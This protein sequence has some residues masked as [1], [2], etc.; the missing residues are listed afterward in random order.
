MSGLRYVPIDW[1]RAEEQA[2]AWEIVAQEVGGGVT[3]IPLPGVQRSVAALADLL[4]EGGF[5]L[6]KAEVHNAEAPKGGTLYLRR[7]FRTTK[8]SLH[9]A[10]AVSLAVKY[11]AD[12]W[13]AERLFTSV[14]EAPEDLLADTRASR[15]LVH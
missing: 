1:I 4:E 9:A 6:I 13:L 10:L 7:W 12:L 5:R 11:G 3:C 15:G 8:L 14:S 2:G